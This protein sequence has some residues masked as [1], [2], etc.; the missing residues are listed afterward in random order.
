MKLPAAVVERIYREFGKEDLEEIQ[1]ALL[2]YGAQPYEREQERV[3]LDI[4]VLSRGDKVKVLD[5]LE[6]AKKDYRDIILWAE[7]P[8]ESKLDTPERIEKFNK[9]LEK[10]G[11][12]WQVPSNKDDK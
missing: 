8:Q 2:T 9:M 11:A 4:L 3:L 7:Y 1:E 10:F 12:T 6:R 5:L